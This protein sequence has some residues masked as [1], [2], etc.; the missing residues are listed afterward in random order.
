MP[1]EWC[2]SASVKEYGL[3]IECGVR[4]I[5]ED[6]YYKLATKSTLD[7]R[8]QYVNFVERCVTTYI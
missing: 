8:S 6:E 4:K 3:R 5:P 2:A 1:L 7:M